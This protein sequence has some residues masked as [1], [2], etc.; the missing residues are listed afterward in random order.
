MNMDHSGGGDL[1]VSKLDIQMIW[2]LV[3]KKKDSPLHSEETILN[4]KCGGRRGG[5]VARE[6]ASH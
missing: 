1:W 5:I 3:G 2:K 4:I 6:A